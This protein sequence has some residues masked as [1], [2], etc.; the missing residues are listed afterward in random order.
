MLKIMFQ[1][2]DEQ[3]DVETEFLYGDLDE[4]I[5]MKIPEGYIEYLAML[6][7]EGYSYD[8]HCCKLNK[9]IYGLVQAVLPASTEHGERT[10]GIPQE[11]ARSCR[12][13]S[14]IPA[15]DTGSS[16]PGPGGALVCRG[17]KTTSG[18]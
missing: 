9:A 1:M 5:Y 14:E 16:T 3:I 15:G 17:A 6:G 2:L 7:L 4:E 13:L 11:L 18:R 12:F 10:I 8:K